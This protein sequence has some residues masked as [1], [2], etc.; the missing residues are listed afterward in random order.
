MTLEGET[1]IKRKMKAIE[2]GQS[3]CFTFCCYI[4]CIYLMTTTRPIELSDMCA[5]DELNRFS[6][7]L[8]LRDFLE[9]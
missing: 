3:T 9:L 8:F 1:R 2:I 7:S 4:D 6:H 5:N